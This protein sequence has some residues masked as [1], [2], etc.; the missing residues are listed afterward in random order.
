MRRPN[1]TAFN[2]KKLNISSY[3]LL[4]Q[5]SGT[6]P[7]SEYSGAKDQWH[8]TADVDLAVMVDYN[9]KNNKGIRRLLNH[10]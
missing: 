6:Q 8:A 1:L 3:S 2:H 5:L 7:V 10:W 4:V 9:F